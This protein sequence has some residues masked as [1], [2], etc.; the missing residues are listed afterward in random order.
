MATEQ[1]KAEETIRFLELFDVMRKRASDVAVSAKHFN[2]LLKSEI[3]RWKTACEN[4]ITPPEP[5][6]L[7]KPKKKKP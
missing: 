5:K 7:L 6:V 1:E 4:I 2:D 3:A